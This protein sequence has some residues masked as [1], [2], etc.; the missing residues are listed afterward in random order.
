MKTHSLRCVSG[1]NCD[2]HVMIFEKLRLKL[3][4]VFN[5]KYS[6]RSVDVNSTLGLA[7]R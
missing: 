2:F 5:F 3:T 7:G 6:G 1:V 4:E